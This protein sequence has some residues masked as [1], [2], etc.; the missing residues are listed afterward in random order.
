[1]TTTSQLRVFKNLTKAPSTKISGGKVPSPSYKRAA[2]DAY[3]TP[4]MA[5][6]ILLE[7]EV[8]KGVIWECAAGTGDISKVLEAK[9]F[10]VVSSDIQTHEGVYGE[11]GVDFLLTDSVVDNVLTNPPYCLAEE[12][13]VHA[14]RLV[15]HKAAFL[16]RIGYLES[17]KRYKI[18]TKLPPSKVIII[19]RRLPFY[20]NEQ[21][22]QGAVFGHCWI[23]WDK[24]HK[25]PTALE[26]GTF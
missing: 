15:K 11:T 6:D 16:V 10:K 8:F 7:K 18:F 14:L 1:M 23:V 21:W 13:I 2:F 17:M 4:K 20:A 26:W 24:Q 9:G 12:F 3:P 22:N 19:S 25:G 5:I